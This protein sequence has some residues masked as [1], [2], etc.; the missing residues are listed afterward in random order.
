[1]MEIKN[2]NLDPAMPKEKVRNGVMYKLI[3]GNI[4]VLSMA[5]EVGKNQFKMRL[6]RYICTN[7]SRCLIYTN[8]SSNTRLIAFGVIVVNKKNKNTLP[9]VE[10]PNIPYESMLRN[11]V[12]KEKSRAK[13]P[14]VRLSRENRNVI[15]TNITQFSISIFRS[16]E[17]VMK[18]LQEETSLTMSLSADGLR[19]CKTN[20]DSMKIESILRQFIKEKVM[21]SQCQS[22]ETDEVAKIC[23]CCKASF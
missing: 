8:E 21:C 13:V 11:I 19:I 3:I 4:V 23:R 20:I 5:E 9:L 2:I 15:W 16:D 12:A 17:S 14:P 1:M 7:E 10:L 22:L 6:E 18:R